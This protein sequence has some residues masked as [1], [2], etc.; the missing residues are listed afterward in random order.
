MNN[1]HKT[2]PVRTPPNNFSGSS[3]TGSQ[4][5]L[6]NIKEAPTLEQ[7]LGRKR[8]QPD[9][10]NITKDE[11][12]EFRSEIMEFLKGFSKS[13]DENHT[14]LKNDVSQIKAQVCVIK[15]TTDQIILEHSAMKQEISELR[16]SLS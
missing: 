11:F 8:K 16:E 15:S 10:Q 14:A 3:Y 13:Q 4:P 6:S 9:D 12:K 1:Q 5:D 7:L 2:T